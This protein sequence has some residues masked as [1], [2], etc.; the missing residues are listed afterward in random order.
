MKKILTVILITLSIT[1]YSQA[2]KWSMSVM[3]QT[4]IGVFNATGVS[5]G[6]ESNLFYKNI[7]INTGYLIGRE[8]TAYLEAAGRFYENNLY[9]TSYVGVWRDKETNLS[10][11]VGLG[12][13]F[14][15]GVTIELSKRFVYHID[16]FEPKGVLSFKVGY[17][18]NSCKT[19]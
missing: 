7:G 2:P 1:A 18:L 16:G 3:P 19:E 14:N 8:K 5:A 10:T 15:S 4:T 9:A 11:G 17:T 6:T 12:Y 13:R